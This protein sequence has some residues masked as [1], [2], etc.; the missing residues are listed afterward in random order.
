MPGVLYD[1]KS[2]SKEIDDILDDPKT[3]RDLIK[4]L[5]VERKK[6]ESPQEIKIILKNGD[7]K[8]IKVIELSLSSHNK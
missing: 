3:G 8:V 6:E 7:Q 4:K 1:T 5:L 2:N